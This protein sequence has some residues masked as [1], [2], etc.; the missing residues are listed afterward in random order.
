VD[1]PGQRNKQEENE[2][3]KERGIPKAW[4]EEKTRNKRRHKDTDDGQRKTKKRIRD[5]RSL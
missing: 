2:T 1:V 4:E 3:I 5:T